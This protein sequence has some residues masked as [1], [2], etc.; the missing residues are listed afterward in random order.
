MLLAPARI[1]PRRLALFWDLCRSLTFA[2]ERTTAGPARQPP[3]RRRPSRARER[4]SPPRAACGRRRRAD[5]CAASVAPRSGMAGAP[6]VLNPRSACTASIRT[7]RAPGDRWQRPRHAIDASSRT[8][9]SS[10]TPRLRDRARGGL[11]ARPWRHRTLQCE[12]AGRTTIRT[13]LRPALDVIE[14]HRRPH[15]NAISSSN[16]R[17]PSLS[18]A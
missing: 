13:A 5:A 4:R 1:L 2:S 18:A 17:R 16:I 15:R 14:N 12:T 9:S 8:A 11:A 10:V 3:R 6:R 7:A